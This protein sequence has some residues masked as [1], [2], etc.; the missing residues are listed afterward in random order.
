MTDEQITKLV[1]GLVREYNKIMREHEGLEGMELEN[2][3][4]S[5]YDGA[6]DA[7]EKVFKKTVNSC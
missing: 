1:Q 6:K 5:Y 2:A 3:C 7:L 4:I